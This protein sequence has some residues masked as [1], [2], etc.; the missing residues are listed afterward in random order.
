MLL[1]FVICVPLTL[2]IILFLLKTK[3]S[4]KLA[5]SVLLASLIGFATAAPMAPALIPYLDTNGHFGFVDHQNNLRIPS[6]FDEVRL[7]SNK[8]AAVRKDKL[9]GF[10]DETGAWKV[11]PRFDG[12]D[13]DSDGYAVAHIYKKRIGLGTPK[14]PRSG[15]DGQGRPPLDLDFSITFRRA[16]TEYF[17]IDQEGKVS[18][19]EWIGEE[20]GKGK[21]GCNDALNAQ[22]K[23]SDTSKPPTPAVN[24]VRDGVEWRW[25]IAD[26]S[27][28]ILTPYM[29][30]TPPRLSVRSPSPLESNPDIILNDAGLAKVRCK[31]QYSFG[32]VDPKGVFL[33]PC[34][35]Q[36][37]GLLAQGN[38]PTGFI[39]NTYDKQTI[40]LNMDGTVRRSLSPLQGS[41][42]E[43]V[44]RN[45][46]LNFAF[47]D[48]EFGEVFNSV[49]DLIHDK[50]LDGKDFGLERQ[51]FETLY[52]L[53]ST[54]QANSPLQIRTRNE[55]SCFYSS[56]LQRIGCQ[57]EGMITPIGQE[58]RNVAPINQGLYLARK[59]GKVGILNH[60]GT[61]II[62]FNYDNISTFDEHGLAKVLLNGQNFYI[63]LEGQE[64]RAESPAPK[65]S[66]YD[67]P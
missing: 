36:N 13:P 29:L 28:K 38:Q 24:F 35:F 14:R 25:A 9:W 63:N 60:Q 10:I 41:P 23:V 43:G 34:K 54:D 20:K 33:I 64:F 30:D 44:L 62:H 48:A 59:A 61:V 18:A 17:C 12:V 32:I 52:V 53:D 67:S 1:C 19:V 22:P 7:F 42:T 37:L 31:K 50:M 45:R 40:V 3:L 58:W 47:K 8:L 51:D 16:S 11:E 6:Q 57:Y 26:A 27:G 5:I 21:K 4:R 2:P 66:T 15:G 46:Y 49:Y 39:G 56:D 55:K 65:S